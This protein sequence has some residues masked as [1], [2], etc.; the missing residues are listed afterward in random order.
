MI[1]VVLLSVLIIVVILVLIY[2]TCFY[3]RR[4]VEHYRLCAKLPSMPLGFLADLKLS[5]RH[6][7]LRPKGWYT[8]L[9]L[10]NFLI[11]IKL[12]GMRLKY[13]NTN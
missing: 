11:Y 13:F 9:L 4:P 3:S 7:M 6:A 12:S 5:Y 10:N 1:F 2:S 8:Y